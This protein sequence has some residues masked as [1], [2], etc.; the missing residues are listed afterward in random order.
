LLLRFDT[1]WAWKGDDVGG[2]YSHSLCMASLKRG[3]AGKG[4]QRHTCLLQ[5]A[6]AS[7]QDWMAAG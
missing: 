2:T 6:F 3:P 5:L 7:E 4:L 1:I